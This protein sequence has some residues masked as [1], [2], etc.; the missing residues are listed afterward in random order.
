MCFYNAYY[1]PFTEIL[2]IFAMSFTHRVARA[3]GFGY[4]GALFCAALPLV[5]RL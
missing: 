2:R 3:S 1:F 4:G 5:K